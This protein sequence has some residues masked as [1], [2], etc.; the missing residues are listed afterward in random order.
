[1]TSFVLVGTDP[2]TA[3]G[4]NAQF[5]GSELHGPFDLAEAHAFASDVV[6]AFGKVAAIDI[7]RFVYGAPKVEIFTVS[8]RQERPL[9][10]LN[11]TRAEWAARNWYRIDE[12]A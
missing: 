10:F 9:A 4:D 3:S 6:E 7:T 12:E 2:S 8:E 1:M 5:A 11:F